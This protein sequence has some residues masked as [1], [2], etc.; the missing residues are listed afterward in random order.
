MRKLFYLSAAV[1]M[2]LAVTAC[3]GNKSAGNDS[4]ASGQTQEQAD[5]IARADSLARLDSI[6]KADSMAKADS[7]AKADSIAKAEK[8]AASG[9]KI[10]GLLSKYQ[11]LGNEIR[12]GFYPDGQ[13]TPGAGRMASETFFNPFAK[14]H[15]QLKGMEKDMTPEQKAKFDKISNRCKEVL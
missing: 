3:G 2:T 11:S 6:A 14:L 8:A 12:E 7:A 13:F 10:D 1:A 15:S 9:K 4:A 5:S